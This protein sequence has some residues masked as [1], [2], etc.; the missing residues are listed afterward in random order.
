V[1]LDA[2]FRNY[3]ISGKVDLLLGKDQKLEVLDFKSQPRPDDKDP[4]IERY[5]KQLNLYA[6]ILKERH[7]KDHNLT[8]QL[9]I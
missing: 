5:K 2:R 8:T 9:N 3:I 1:R 7:K 6:Y 4:I